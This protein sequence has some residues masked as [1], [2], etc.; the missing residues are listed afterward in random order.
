MGS[1]SDEIFPMDL[2]R[3][4][5]YFRTKNNYSQ[6]DLAAAVGITASYLSLI[7]ANLRMPT[8]SLMNKIAEH[9]SIPL[10][11]LMFYSLEESDIPEKKR[12]LFN[13]FFE[14]LKNIIDKSFTNDSQ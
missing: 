3:T 12:H 5:K 8:V 1:S 14:P 11:V 7:E 4:L 13:D 9:F 10:P 6:K 2:G